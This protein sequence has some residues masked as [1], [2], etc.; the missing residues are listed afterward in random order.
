LPCGNYDRH[1]IASECEVAM[2]LSAW[3]TSAGTSLGFVAWQGHPETKQH[4]MIWL[5]VART[6]REILWNRQWMGKVS[7]FLYD[8][9]PVPEW[10]ESPVG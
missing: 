8:P 2:S 5:A 6:G 9:T 4:L 1:T 7:D 10:A 3:I